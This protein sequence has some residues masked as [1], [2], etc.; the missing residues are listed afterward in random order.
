[1]FPTQSQITLTHVSN[2][3]MVVLPYQPQAFA[4]PIRRASEA[5]I[6]R[7]ARIMK[8][9]IQ[10]DDVLKKLQGENQ[11]EMFA[12]IED[13][14]TIPLSEIKEENIAIFLTLEEALAFVK[15]KYEEG[16]KK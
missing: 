7:Q 1:M 10:G 14:K 12:D 4:Q 8:D 2:G 6:R 9:E 15:E 16:L 13:F 5:E 11:D 3:W